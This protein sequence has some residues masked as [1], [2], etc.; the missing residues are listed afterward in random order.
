MSS[1]TPFQQ[2]PRVLDPDTIAHIHTYLNAFDPAPFHLPEDL[3][4]QMLDTLE[5]SDQFLP[6]NASGINLRYGIAHPE[7]LRWK[8]IYP[9]TQMDSAQF[10]STETQGPDAATWKKVVQHFYAIGEILARPKTHAQRAAWMQMDSFLLTPSER[11]QRAELER[12][13]R[14]LQHLREARLYAQEKA[15]WDL[16][17]INEADLRAQMEAEEVLAD[18]PDILG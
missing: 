4:Q 12:Q 3:Y 14:Q 9:A 16:L 7:P 8:Y 5:N 2:D 18:N 15:D 13:Q 6:M 1:L 10:V 17:A 11:A